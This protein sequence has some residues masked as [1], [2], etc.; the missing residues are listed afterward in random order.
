MAGCTSLASMIES[1]HRRRR[2]DAW[3][4]DEVHPAGPSQRESTVSV[5]SCSSSG[6][7]QHYY[8]FSTESITEW[9]RTGAMHRPH[10]HT[11]PFRG[12]DHLLLSMEV[13][14]SSSTAR[15]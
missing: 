2:N 15:Y 3:P 5:L 1:R 14:K 7:H 10:R 13:R 8:D 4:S 6:Q 11:R 9:A 12:I